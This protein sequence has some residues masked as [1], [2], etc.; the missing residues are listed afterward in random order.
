VDRCVVARYHHLFAGLID[1][2]HNLL[3]PLP[4]CIE[5]V[6]GLK[7]VLNSGMNLAEHVRAPPTTRR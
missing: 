4:S 1:A 5:G 7:Q 3:A 6:P 2:L